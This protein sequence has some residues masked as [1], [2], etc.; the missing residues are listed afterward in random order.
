MIRENYWT[1]EKEN[2]LRKHW[3]NK[4]SAAEIVIA[5]GGGDLTR[6]AV[7]GKA[8]RLKL[9][10]RPSPIHQTKERMFGKISKLSP[11]SFS[12]PKK[13]VSRKEAKGVAYGKEKSLA[14]LDK[15]ECRYPTEKRD[16]LWMFCAGKRNG[17]SPYCH[18]HQKLCSARTNV[19]DMQENS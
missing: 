8:Y 11:L 4:L 3:N 9:D 19:V 12:K 17:E 5:M 14:D 18:H 2:E 16:G 7:I 15:N 13:D 10:A 1:P 6:N